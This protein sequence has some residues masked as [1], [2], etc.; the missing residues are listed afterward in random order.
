MLLWFRA[1]IFPLIGTIKTWS[2]QLQVATSAM[3]RWMVATSSFLLMVPRISLEIMSFVPILCIVLL[4]NPIPRQNTNVVELYARIIKDDTQLTYY[5]SGIGTYA[6]PSWRSFTYWKQV[7]DNK[8]DL[9]IAWYH[10]HHHALL[11]IFPILYFR[12][13]EKIVVAAYRWLSDHYQPGDKIFLF[14]M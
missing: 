11:Y 4:L 10:P 8:I 6:R 9:A 1:H 7:L 5:N 14:G 2:L 13:F 12:N 3:P